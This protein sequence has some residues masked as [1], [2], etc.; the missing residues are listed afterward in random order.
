MKF[1]D[2]RCLSLFSH[3]RNR[4]KIFP[5]TSSKITPNDGEKIETNIN[6]NQDSEDIEGIDNSVSFYRN[7]ERIC[8]EIDNSA[9]ENEIPEEKTLSSTNNTDV[10]FECSSLNIKNIRNKESS[11]ESEEDALENSDLYSIQNRN[12]DSNST[13]SYLDSNSSLSSLLSESN[14]NSDGKGG[15]SCTVSEKRCPT[16]FITDKKNTIPEICKTKKPLK[17]REICGRTTSSCK[18]NILL[19]DTSRSESGFPK[20]SNIVKNRYDFQHLNK[21]MLDKLNA[22]IP[23]TRMRNRNSVQR[24]ISIEKCAENCDSFMKT[25]PTESDPC[26]EDTKYAKTK[27]FG[28]FCTKL[29]PKE[30][31][32]DSNWQYIYDCDCEIL[33]ENI[34]FIEEP[35]HLCNLMKLCD[36]Q[37]C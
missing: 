2:N 8:S 26:E 30:S 32:L 37:F 10:R 13:Y 23:I 11:Q 35:C 20:N 17:R 25:N 12:V 31:E 9:Q 34:L 18:G 4:Y 27:V 15:E 3:V 19:G 14:S 7:D 24:I 16:D 5:K 36:H 1:K 22:K 21:E 33:F 28:G 6:L 29:V